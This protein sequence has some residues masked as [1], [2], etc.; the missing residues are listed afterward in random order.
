M[1][2]TEIKNLAQFRDLLDS[3]QVVIIDAWAE[4]CGPCRMISPIFE[5][6]SNEEGNEGVV[7]TK[8]DVDNAPDVSEELGIQA[9]PTFILFHKGDKVDE[10]KG[11]VPPKLM[12]LVAKAN[13]LVD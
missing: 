7:F 9:M 5:K 6:L 12:E 1:P 3:N 11:A 10:L 8:V 2:V 13:S 4:W